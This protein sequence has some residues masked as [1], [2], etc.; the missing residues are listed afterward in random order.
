MPQAAPAIE[1]RSADRF[2]LALPITMEGEDCAS[3]DLSA[4]GLL[5]E[6]PSAPDVG[7]LV[8]LTLEYVAQGQEL[9][10]SVQG[11]VVRV[12]R[13]G[14]GYNVGVRLAQPLFQQEQAGGRS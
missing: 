3:H 11:E 5:V 7:A 8:N 6:A 13:H 12:E 1:Q 4:T 10:L 9:S 2:G 14:D